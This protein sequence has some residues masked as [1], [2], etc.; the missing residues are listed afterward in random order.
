[1]GGRGWDNSCDFKEL[2]R[3]REVAGVFASMD[4]SRRWA[5]KIYGLD[6]YCEPLWILVG[7]AERGDGIPGPPLDWT[8]RGKEDLVFA[9]VD[10]LT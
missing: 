3:L 6:N 10:Q 1:M 8:E 5:L 2:G 4:R 7:P 9:R